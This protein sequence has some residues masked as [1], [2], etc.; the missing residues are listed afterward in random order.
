MGPALLEEAMKNWIQRNGFSGWK[1]WMK[2]YSGE[3]KR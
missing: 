2:K 3:V 1:E